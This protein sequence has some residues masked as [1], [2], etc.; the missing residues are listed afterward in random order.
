MTYTI[1]TQH[2]IANVHFDKKER[3]V[4]CDAQLAWMYG[5]SRQE[6]ESICIRRGYTFTRSD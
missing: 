6:V 1:N 4:K 2:H 5:R 3:V